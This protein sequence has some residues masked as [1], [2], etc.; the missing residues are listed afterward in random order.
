M[1]A[2]A[3]Q[4]P[5]IKYDGELSIAIGSSRKET[6]W[7]NKNMTW[8]ELLQK[9]AVTTR[10]KETFNEYKHMTKDRQSEVKDVGGYVG[11]LLKNGRRKA[12]QAAWR[13]L[14]TLDADYADPELLDS[15]D[16][17]FSNSMAAYS[18]HSHSPEKPR[19]R[20][21][22]PLKRQV[23]PDE[24]NALS[25]FVAAE[26]GIDYFDDTTYQ[27]ERLMYWPSTAEDGE[28][29]FTHIDGPW[30]D[31]D[32]LLE[33]HERWFDAS[34]WPESSRAVKMRQRHADKQGHPHEKPGFVGA[35][36]RVYDIPAAID[37]FLSEKYT[38]CDV[39]NRY[40]YTEGS[41]A[42]GLVVYDGDLFAFSNHSTDPAGGMLC[43]AFDLV[44][45]HLFGMKDEDEPE[46]TPVHLLPSYQAMQEF[47]LKDKPVKIE[48]INSKNAEVAQDFA[49]GIDSEEDPDAWKADIDYTAKGSIIKS[50][51]NALLIIRN[52]PS[53]KG[54]IGYDEF[55]RRTLVRKN[56]PW[57]TVHKGTDWTDADDSGLRHY[58]E[59]H[60]GFRSDK[61]IKDAFLIAMKDNTYHPIKEY[62]DRLKWDGVSRLDTVL[63]DY[64]GAEDTCYNRAISR[65]WLVAAAGR[66][67]DPGC[68]FDNML[69]LVGKQG[70][71]KSQ[72]FNR[73]SVKLDWFSDS[74]SR[75]DNSKD[76]MEQLSGKWIIELGELS[77][78]KKSEVEHIKTFLS[79]QEDTY[80]QAYGRN[81][82]TYRRQCVFAG[83]TNRDDF[84]T[85]ST[86]NRRFWTVKVGDTSKL[87]TGMTQDVVDQIWAEADIIYSLGESLYLEGQEAKEVNERQKA[88]TDTGGK[89]G[90]AGE[91]LEMKV[92]EDWKD[93][94]IQ[95]R[96][97]YLNGFDFGEPTTGECIRDK[98]S[99]IELFVECFNGRPE[100]YTRRD[101]YE[102]T[103]ILRSLGW[104]SGEKVI[105]TKAYGV[106]K[107]FIKSK[108]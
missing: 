104:E 24:Y 25:R 65:K 82:E 53:L 56:L 61:D 87:W 73:L 20:L 27:P 33:K 92:P 52:D 80:R 90:L 86:G 69:I 44:R 108:E 89:A 22:I 100:N 84:L 9:L 59:M 102:M 57:R 6:R 17:M 37:H 77:V 67:R 13:S 103:D 75:I 72:F 76:S 68:K 1:K 78:M 54:T 71:G 94:S 62:F 46:N 26:I 2:D 12:G 96:L 79:K 30:L 83:T 14:I 35:F 29:L 55:K 107:S 49:E 18:T 36:N 93:Y 5:Q 81:I 38:Q 91:F 31:P 101:S 34:T 99:G 60:Y 43:N 105:R 28:Y 3:F 63:I 4:K 85:D 11:G 51:N 70:V 16:L 23:S 41:T 58:M 66:I 48:L 10:T 64:L 98:I 39:P 42:A 45:V 74:M 88:Y 7:K 15:L 50:I 8:S 97:D 32:A 95:Q 106:Q 40:T 21:V 19:L 47:A